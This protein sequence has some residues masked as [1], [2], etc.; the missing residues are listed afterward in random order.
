MKKIISNE[1]TKL[2]Y[3]IPLAKNLARKKFIS[4]FLLG[5]IDS[6]KIQ[7][8]EVALH[9]EST[10]KV[11]SVERTI[12]SFFKEYEFDYQQVCVLLVMFL[13]RDKISLS[14]DRTEWDFGSYQCNILMIV[15]KSDSIG[16]PLYWDL[17]DNKSGNS[18]CENR[19]SLLHKVIEVVGKERVNFIVGDREFIGLS[20]IK[21]LKDS[22][23]P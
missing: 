18:N 12:Q 23:I 1:V 11:E 10:A 3:K 13:R 15:A 16:I 4:S 6:R 5:L 8:Q 2:L 20:W 21:Y 7:F 14:I 17:L 9:M 19:I 22:K